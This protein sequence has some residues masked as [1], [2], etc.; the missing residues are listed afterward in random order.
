MY[1]SLVTGSS[2][3][4]M[5]EAN[6]SRILWLYYNDSVRCARSVVSH[7]QR[8]LFF[9]CAGNEI[10]FVC[11]YLMDFYKQPLELNLAAVL[12]K[13]AL[14]WLYTHRDSWLSHAALMAVP[15]L[16]WPQIVGGL[17]LPICFAKQVINC[18]QFWKASKTLVGIDLVER[19]ARV[20]KKY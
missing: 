20:A 10:F 8:T 3:H 6:V 9:F 2:S 1:S 14:T 4:K 11:L 18:V 15:R 16:T 13:Y 19:H 5:I 7:Q 12:P 17:T